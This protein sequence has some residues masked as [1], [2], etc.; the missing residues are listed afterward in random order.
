MKVALAQMEV[1][2]GQPE[3]NLET[4]LRM[5]E[6]AKRKKVDLVVFPEMAVGGY[7]LGDKWLD[8]SFCL[9]LMQFNK[10]IQEAS[11]GIAIAYGNVFLD[12]DI[13]ER[14]NDN[15]FHPNKDGRLRKYNAL[16]VFQNGLPAKRVFETSIL[17]PG[18]QP[19]VLL[20][21]YRF[22]DDERYFFSLQ[23]VA[24]DFSVSL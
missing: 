24:K 1:I 22:F 20:P 6:D 2:P 10:P 9:D 21:N 15:K 18:V 23:D 5:I 3:E 4:I 17:P 12:I 8:E 14:V 13:N 19:K 7:I 16:Y 11:S